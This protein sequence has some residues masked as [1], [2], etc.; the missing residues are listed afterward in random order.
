MRRKKKT[1]KLVWEEA[2]DI[3]IRIEKIA[4]SVGEGWLDID[5]IFCYRSKNSTARVYARIWGLPRVWQQALEIKPA[6]VIEVLSEEFDRLP[7]KRQDEVLMHE[8]AHIP[9]NFSGSLL[10]HTR[11]GKRNFEDRVRNLM[12]AYNKKK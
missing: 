2:V 6:Y 12:S 3:K 9:R 10:P 8:L 4:D 7:K 1:E 5:R 11:K